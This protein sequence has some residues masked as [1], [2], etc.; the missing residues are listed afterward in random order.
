LNNEAKKSYEV[1]LT[2]IED[3]AD[4]EMDETEFTPISINKND[5][6]KVQCIIKQTEKSTQFCRYILKIINAKVDVIAIIRE[7]KMSQDE[8][9]HVINVK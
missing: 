5:T 1:S 6:F 8:I 9:N 4:T 2:I 7:K 3:Q